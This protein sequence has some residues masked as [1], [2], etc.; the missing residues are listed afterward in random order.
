MRR[1]PFLFLIVS[2]LVA[3][4]GCDDGDVSGGANGI[5]DLSG[6]AFAVVGAEDAFANIDD[7]TLDHEMAMGPV[8]DSDGS[9]RRHPGHPGHGGS[10]LGI[11]LRRLQLDPA[12]VDTIRAILRTHRAE[13]R[14]ILEQLR[15]INQELIDRANQE[16]M[17]IVEA[18]RNGELDPDEARE[19]LRRLSQAT[20]E[21]I[22]SNPENAPYLAALCEAKRELF[23]DIRAVLDDAQ[24]ATWD[25]WVVRLTGPCLGD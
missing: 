20:R 25:D 21:A 23:A 9:F 16:R 10:H 1:L 22:R 5:A 24:R 4:P 18:V 15:L 14:P 19:M 6:D 2:A 17:R 3:V 7:A 8:M 12:Q 11:V 13:V